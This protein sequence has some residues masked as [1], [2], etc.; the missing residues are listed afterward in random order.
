MGCGVIG[1]FTCFYLLQKYPNCKATIYAD[2][3]PRFGDKDNSQLI[4]SQVAPGFWFPFHFGGKNDERNQRISE[5]S[6]QLYTALSREGQYRQWVKQVDVYE[7][8]DDKEIQEEYSNFLPEQIKHTFREVDVLL[9]KQAAKARTLQS[10]KIDM[11]PFLHRF[12]SQLGQKGVQFVQRTF[13][14]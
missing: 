4:T 1:L 14:P 10:L 5:E 7:I 6:F 13:T 2:K 12:A 8:A 11:Q 9:G 3:I